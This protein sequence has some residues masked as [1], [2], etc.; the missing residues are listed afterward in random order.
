MRARLPVRSKSRVLMGPLMRMRA[1][2]PLSEAVS[3]DEA[4]PD[5]DSARGQM[6]LQEHVA[7]KKH[8]LRLGAPRSH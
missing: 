3:R 5:L 7:R 1:G 8:G 6:R 2:Q 4:V